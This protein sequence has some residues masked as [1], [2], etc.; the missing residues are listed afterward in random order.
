M[1]D[2]TPV[3]ATSERWAPVAKLTDRL[4]NLPIWK[5]V[6]FHLDSVDGILLPFLAEM[7]EVTETAAWQS[8]QSE[9]E[10]RAII[11]MAH[12]RHRTVGTPAGLIRA[13]AEAGG[14][15][16][17]IWAP[18]SKAFPGSSL[19]PA[20]KNE[21]LAQHPELRMYPRRVPGKQEV[22]MC[23]SAFPFSGPGTALQR[24]RMRVTLVKDGV[25]TELETASWDIAN[26]QK[27]VVNEI[28]IPGK[29][30]Y[31]SFCGRPLMFTAATDASNR[32]IVLKDVKLY[33]EPKATLGLRTITPGY[34]PLEADSEM[35]SEVYTASKGASFCGRFLLYPHRS[36][37]ANRTYR[38]IRLFDPDVPLVKARAS[39]HAGFTRLGM[40]PHCA[41]VE[42]EFFGRRH[43]AIGRFAGVPIGERNPAPFEKLLAN[44]RLA[45][46]ASDSIV[47]NTR[48]F[49]P[50]VAG[51]PLP[52]GTLAGG[53]TNE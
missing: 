43:P 7:F 48:I 24:S 12:A 20:Q 37:A 33:N 27:E 23:G 32:M 42:V 47:I 46:R 38:R 41:E 3:L 28:K 40:P 16:R 39:A 50:A 17:R 5:N 13:A 34:E 51:Q 15:V 36:E 31:A 53:W 6:V 52:V 10:R 18:P 25:E 21:W 9:K 44:M 29:A 22:G 14:Q 45:T 26:V 19:T 30:G 11:K 8:A 4:F 35:V 2:I 49:R 1:T